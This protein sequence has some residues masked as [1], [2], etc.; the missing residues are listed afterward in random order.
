MR[1]ADSTGPG[2]GD[3]A[4]CSRSVAGEPDIIRHAEGVIKVAGFVRIQFDLRVV[5]DR[6]GVENSG[7]DRV[8]VFHR[9]PDGTQDFSRDGKG[10]VSG[11]CA[12]EGRFKVIQI[13]GKRF[14]LASRAEAEVPDP[15]HQRFSS[16]HQCRLKAEMLGQKL[17]R[18]QAER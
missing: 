10:D 12:F 3:S 17:V 16:A 7:N 2:T 11:G 15:L 4:A 6:G 14:F 8:E 9:L 5:H 18:W 13:P 1:S